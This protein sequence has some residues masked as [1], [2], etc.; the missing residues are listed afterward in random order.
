MDL[1]EQVRTTEQALKERIERFSQN[2]KPV[3]AKQ[4]LDIDIEL[5]I[6]GENHFI[7]GYKSCIVVAISQGD[8]LIDLHIIPIWKCERTFLGMSISR[9]IPG[10]KVVGEFTDE[11]IEEV[12]E[13]LKEYVKEICDEHSL[14]P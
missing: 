1:L 11:S 10:S 9:S 14:T 6:E 12:C 2:Y 3:F 7:P 5:D 8:E 4:N 13:E